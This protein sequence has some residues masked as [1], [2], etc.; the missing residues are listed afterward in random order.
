[1]DSA[2]TVTRSSGVS[3]QLCECGCGLPTQISPRTSTKKRWVKG[4]PRRFAAP[5]HNA[6]VTNRPHRILSEDDWQEEERGY[7]SPCWIWQDNRD[8]SKQRFPHRMLMLNRKRVAAHRAV[9]ELFVGAIPE[10]HHLHHLCFQCACVNP[11]HLVPMTPSEH[12]REHR[13]LQ[14]EGK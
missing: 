7:L 13:R 8:E 9:Y 11:D 14:R 10:G 2:N 5:G 1:M 12:M 3:T 6:I 4:Q